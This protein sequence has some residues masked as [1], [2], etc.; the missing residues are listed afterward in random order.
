MGNQRG[1]DRTDGTD[2]TE[3]FVYVD[4]Y[5]YAD[6][7]VGRDAK[8]HVVDLV[9]ADDAVHGEGKLEVL[10]LGWGRLTNYKYAGP[11]HRLNSTSM[12]GA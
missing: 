3:G 11:A 4:R 2:W 9:V 10:L 7:F 12:A 1:S 8:A 6:R 5:V